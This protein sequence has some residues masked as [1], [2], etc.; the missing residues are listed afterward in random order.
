MRETVLMVTF[1]M[2]FVTSISSVAQI[3]VCLDEE[4]SHQRKVNSKTPTDT[5]SRILMQAL[6]ASLYYL[7]NMKF[8]LAKDKGSFYEIFP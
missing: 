2:P 3:T 7:D 4:E 8:S 5:G 6:N 1:R